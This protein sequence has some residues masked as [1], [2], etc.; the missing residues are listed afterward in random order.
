[1]TDKELKTEFEKL[2]QH[3]MVWSLFVAGAVVL[4]Y[5]LL[6]VALANPK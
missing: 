1:M 2:Q 4:T 5:I 3:V 6:L